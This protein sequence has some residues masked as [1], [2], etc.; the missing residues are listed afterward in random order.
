M[1]I[2]IRITIVSLL[3]SF[4]IAKA[5]SVS[6]YQ[7]GSYQPGLLNLRDLATIE[8]PGLLFLD[9]N[10]WNNSNS[11]V[12][13]FGDEVSS[14]EIFQTTL[15]LSVQVSGYINVP[16]LFYASN[17]KILGGRYMASINPVFLSSNYKM[18]IHSTN[19]ESELTSSG[20]TGGIG[21]MA[22]M[23]FGLGWSFNN[24]IDFS[25]FY[26]TYIPTG[27]YKTGA[28]DN[29]GKGYWTHQFQLPTYF[30][31]KE[32]ATAFLIM[33][34]FEING[35]VKDSDVQAGNRLTI[36][37]GISQYLNSWLELEIL[38]GHNWQISNDKGEDVWWSG[39]PLDSKDQTSTV[40]FGAGIWTYKS[41]LNLRLKYAMDYGTKQRYKSNFLSFSFIFIPNILTGT[42]KND[43]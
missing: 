40:S 3:F 17:F 28:S 18:N 38:N 24:K 36:E 6:A 26:T 19:S 8:T 11:Y 35:K 43:I 15:D 7:A 2:L 21:D 31:L 25:F 34:T 42:A 14:I 20:N 1:L 12:D 22:I 23:P 37:Y 10:Y 33:P 27:K 39:T 4:S 13:R 9:Y 32:K 30:Y 5:Q 41:R 29:L 16:V